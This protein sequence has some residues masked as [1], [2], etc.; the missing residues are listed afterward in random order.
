MKKLIF[1][2]LI[3]LTF[4]ITGCGNNK[5]KRLAKYQ[6]IMEEYSKDY[7]ENYFKDIVGLDVLEISINM[8]ENANKVA[9]ANYDLSKLKDCDKSS[10][11][12]LFLS[13][14]GNNIKRYQYNLNCK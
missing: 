12:M 1:I 8:L 2:S 7:F 13:N 4:F 9:N 10:T 3:I 11:I 6:S 5:E 14:N